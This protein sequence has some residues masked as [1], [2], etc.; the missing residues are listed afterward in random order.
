MADEIK[1]TYRMTPQEITKGVRADSLP[2]LN[3]RLEVVLFIAYLLLFSLLIAL[4]LIL[5]QRAAVSGR[6]PVELFTEL[7]PFV[8]PISLSGFLVFANPLLAWRVR[9]DPKIPSEQFWEFSDAHVHLKSEH[10]EA[11]KAWSAFPRA[12]EDNRF[13][14]LY[15]SAS[16]D[17]CY[18]IPKQALASPA[19]E[20]KL[21]DLFKRKIAKW[22]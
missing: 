17:I 6:S 10:G 20:S 4:L 21:R 15:V 9:R 7:W 18:L 11:L 22:V 8:I 2:S 13:F 1:I 14:Y 5:I 12:G 3:L 16:Q 19:E